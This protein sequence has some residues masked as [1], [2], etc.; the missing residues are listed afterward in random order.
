MPTS[1][2]ASGAEASSA[3]TPCAMCFRRD[4]SRRTSPQ[5]KYRVPGSMPSTNMRQYGAITHLVPTRKSPSVKPTEVNKAATTSGKIRRHLRALGHGLEPV[6]QIGKTGLSSGVKKE[7]EQ[8]L[9]A[10]ELI[11]VRLL[12][13]CPIERKAAGKQLSLGTGAAHVQTVG[14]VVL[15]YRARP[16]KPRI[17]FSG[18]DSSEGKRSSVTTP[19]ASSRTAATRV[20]QRPAKGRARPSGYKKK[21]QST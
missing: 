8:A 15:L 9:H 18:D 5:P 13:E 6:V 2:C 10:H 12:R 3:T 11:K 17:A 16:E 7:L 20:R 1:L 4:D 21:R 19:K 14:S